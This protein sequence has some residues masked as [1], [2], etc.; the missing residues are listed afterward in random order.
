MPQVI[1]EMPV[2]V[3]IVSHFRGAVQTCHYKFRRSCQAALK[4]R[5][6]EI[7]HVRVRS[8]YRRV[9]VLLRREGWRHGQ[10]KNR[11]V[12]RER[13]LQLRNKSPKRWVKAK[14]RDDRLPA[15]RANEIWPMDLV[16]DQLATGGKLRVLSITD[17]FSRFSPAQEPRLTLHGTDV[18]DVLERLC[19]EVRIPATIGID[20]EF[21][22]RDLHLWAYQRGATLGFSRQAS[23]PTM[24]LSKPSMGASGPNVSMLI[25]FCPLRRPRKRLRLEADAKT[26]NGPTWRSAIG[27][28]FCCENTALPAGQRDQRRKT[29]IPAGP[30]FGLAAPGLD[31]PF[32]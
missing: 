17:I 14:L 32:L 30:K 3:I 18:V 26:R 11:R 15:T 21:V 23:R 12:Y 4:A 25:D 8:A 27:R 7:C 29:L 6:E 13:G 2:N 19:N 1:L 10:N 9:H 5:I 28:R 31:Y 22:S 20:Q 24:P 16:H